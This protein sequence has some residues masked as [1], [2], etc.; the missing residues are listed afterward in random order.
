MFKFERFKDCNWSLF[1]GRGRNVCPTLFLEALYC[2]IHAY[3]TGTNVFPYNKYFWICSKNSLGALRSQEYAS[4]SSGSREEAAELMESFTSV[5]RITKKANLLPRMLFFLFVF[6]SEIP[7]ERISNLLVLHSHWNT[8]G[9]LVKPT[10]Q[11]KSVLQSKV[12]FKM[13]IRLP[14]NWGNTCRWVKCSVCLT[15]TNVR[16]FLKHKAIIHLHGH[17]F[18]LCLALP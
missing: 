10:F 9:L 3:H 14:V 6:D 5:I 12:I 7:M 8:S 16:Y 15:A 13:T 2:V 11:S 17:L 1:E 18:G 4:P